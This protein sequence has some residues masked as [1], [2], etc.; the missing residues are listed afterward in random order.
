ME[1]FFNIVQNKA[2]KS[3]DIHI[4]ASI[5]KS[6][7]DNSDDQVYAAKFQ[8]ELAKTN[9]A[10]TLNIF[11]NSP[12]GLVSDGI[13]IMNYII[14]HPAATKNVTIT[15][16]AASIASCIA[17]AGTHI[18]MPA[19]AQLMIHDPSTYAYGNSKQLRK[20]A[21]SLDK[22]KNSIMNAYKRRDLTIDDAELGTLMTDETWMSAE[23][24]LDYGFIDE[25]TDQ[26]AT[27]SNEVFNSAMMHSFHRIPGQ[28]VAMALSV[29]PVK[30]VEVTV[31]DKEI[32][33]M[34]GE[35][36]KTP[37]MTAEQVQE[38]LDK[39]LA[40]NNKQHDK[41][42]FVN[43]LNQMAIAGKITP[44]EAQ[45]HA[46]LGD[47][48]AGQTIKN[49]DGTEIKAT[50]QFLANLQ[51]RPGHE[52]TNDNAATAQAA[53]AAGSTATGGT[54][55]T[56]AGQTAGKFNMTKEEIP[57]NVNAN[58]HV[59]HAWVTQQMT[60]K[61]FDVHNLRTKEAKDAFRE[62]SYRAEHEPEVTAVLDR[63]GLRTA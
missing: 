21:A 60:A 56:A 23:E 37:G 9:D 8:K 33:T 6:Y 26:K 53:A 50:E 61:G 36:T 31:E 29:P 32:E 46:A 7:W 25:V 5:G 3:A 39:S 22:A 28:L 59:T 24:A 38:M 44:A 48:L 15:G 14:A 45:A 49:T 52:L 27:I 4:N 2:A 47:S 13:A 19:T 41:T 40:A 17:M 35:E 62:F 63:L 16:V 20:M 58:A 51:G 42:N 43:A 54:T 1:Q 57:D 55:T 10:E 34:A 30:A 18:K 11:I 12:G